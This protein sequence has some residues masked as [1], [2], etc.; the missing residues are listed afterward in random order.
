M[1]KSHQKLPSSATKIKTLKA[2][3]SLFSQMFI[4]CQR[5]QVD[6]DEFFSHENQPF[7]PSLAE[8]G[9][10]RIPHSKSDLVNCLFSDVEP[11]KKNISSS[12]PST[13]VIIDGAYIAQSTRPAA[14]MTFN[15]YAVEKFKKKV[16][17]IA[18]SHRATRADVVFDRYLKSSIKA[19]A[20]M[21][22]GQ[23]NE[24]KVKPE[25]CVA[26]NWNVFL[27]NG[28]NKTELFKFLAAKLTSEC[29]DGDPIIVSTTEQQVVT[30]NT[31]LDNMPLITP[32]NHEEA[33][34]RMLLHANHASK[35]G[36]EHVTIRS[37]DTDVL[38]LSVHFFK[39]L[40]LQCLWVATGIGS[41]FR[42]LPVHEICNTISPTMTSG[43]LFYHAFS[44]CDSVFSFANVGKKTSFTVANAHSEIWNTFSELSVSPGDISETQISNVE[45]Y[46][47]YLYDQ[48]SNVKE[49][50]KARRHLVAIGRTA[51]RVPPTS[52]AL[53]Q[54]I[55][56]SAYQAGHIW[57]CSLIA[58][59]Q[60]PPVSEWGWK[61]LQDGSVEPVWTVLPKA[62]KAYRAL[63][64]CSCK[65]GCSVRCKCHMNYKLPCT[66]LCKCKGNCRNNERNRA[67]C[68]SSTLQSA[69]EGTSTS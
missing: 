54:H 20:R 12:P 55:K 41:S 60:L 5:R 57:A 47:V 42:Y 51:D 21:K 37:A 59:P 34:T 31:T 32:C 26:K 43:L 14:V 13:C 1:I 44:G 49:V 18:S 50:N 61:V 38:I 9:N 36:H 24:R 52:A 33:D 56:R 17:D 2:D 7:P 27:L 40:N 4:A 15:Q 64:K 35:T 8:N 22:R 25:M 45:E 10:I 69:S 68:I 67:E 66:E 62:S 6:L 3:Y 29:I 58:E 53:L 65:K 16:T 30:S 39:D 11:G 23:S 46:T 63:F 19:T 48:A 28:K